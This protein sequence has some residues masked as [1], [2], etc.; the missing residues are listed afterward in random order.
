VISFGLDLY[1]FFDSLLFEESEES[2]DYGRIIDSISERIEMSNEKIIDK[3]ELQSYIT[4]L[5]DIALIIK[6]LLSEIMN[7]LKKSGHDE[8]Y[9][10]RKR[11]VDGFKCNRVK[12]YKI[13]SLLTFKVSFDESSN[14]L[15]SFIVK[16]Y[17]G[18]IPEFWEFKT[19]Y[20]T[21]VSD[22]VAMALLYE[23]FSDNNLYNETLSS[24]RQDIDGIFRDFQE[25]EDACVKVSLAQ[26]KTDFEK[27][28]KAGELYESN[29]RKYPHLIS[30]TIR[31]GG[32][33]CA[34]MINFSKSQMAIQEHFNL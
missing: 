1:S 2:I 15:L 12:I 27:T 21:L 7:I 30:D 19:Y 25:Q 26:A 9:E 34:D 6:Q 20:M 13:K 23:K 4:E 14:S 33:Y 29:H 31:L 10:Y 8:A 24:W 32:S 3:I 28:S 16:Q 11:F 5:R 22:V 18:S 17:D